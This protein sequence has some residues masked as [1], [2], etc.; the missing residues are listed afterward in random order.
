MPLN[1]AEG[2]AQAIKLRRLEIHA[3]LTEWKRA[4]IVEGIQRPLADRVT[5]EAE[6]AQLALEARVNTAAAMAA[7]VE[8][9]ERIN[10]DV[11]GQ[12]VTLLADRGMSDLVDE[13]R[14][15]AALEE[16]AA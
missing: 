2:R 16:Q 7:K 15:L 14:R 4:F 9:R 6:D 13:A 5:L 11:L 1:T 10:A 3:T 12:L 8:R